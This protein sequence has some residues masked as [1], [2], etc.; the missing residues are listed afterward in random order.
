MALALGYI[1]KMVFSVLRCIF[2]PFASLFSRNYQDCR[3]SFSCFIQSQLKILG[4]LKPI[5]EIC[6]SRLICL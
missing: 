2:L 6:D 4:R 3:L 5:S 1:K